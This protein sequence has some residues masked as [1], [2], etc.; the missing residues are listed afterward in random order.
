MN[1]VFLTGF[2]AT[3]KSVV[4]R[5]LARRLGRPFADADA[6]IEREAGMTIAEVFERFG[7]AE[8]RARERRWIERASRLDDAVIATGGGAVV[9]PQSRR[10]MHACGTLV[11]LSA[12]VDTILRRLGSAANRPLVADPA[13]RE[14]RIRELL[15]DRAGA[16]ADADLVVDTSSRSPDEVVETIVAWLATA[17]R[18]PEPFGE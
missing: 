17:S 16:Y 2:M 3:G 12:D 13:R 10:A 7:E 5:A 18:R 1:N 14:A 8:F 4:G 9:D 15:R 11:C 6:E